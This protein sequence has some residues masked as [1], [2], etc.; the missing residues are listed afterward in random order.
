MMMIGKERWLK[1]E[2]QLKREREREL[3]SQAINFQPE[4]DDMIAMVLAIRCR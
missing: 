1:M 2:Q 4:D 3:D